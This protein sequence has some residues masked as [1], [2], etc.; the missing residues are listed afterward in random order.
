MRAAVTVLVARRRPSALPRWWQTTMFLPAAIDFVVTFWPLEVSRLQYLTMWDKTSSTLS[1]SLAKAL[2]C[3][4][5][6]VLGPGAEQTM[7]RVFWRSERS[8]RQ[9]RASGR[10]ILELSRIA[11]MPGAYRSARAGQTAARTVSPLM[12]RMS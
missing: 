12:G 9:P 5:C 11:E 6:G 10:Q 3:D 2:T 1:L 4:V 7:C 8:I